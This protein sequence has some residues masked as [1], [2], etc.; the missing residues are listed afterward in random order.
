MLVVLSQTKCKGKL[1]GYVYHWL[2]ALAVAAVTCADSN[3]HRNG[4][5]IT[6]VALQY[7]RTRRGLEPKW[8]LLC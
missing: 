8:L 2:A 3:M 4:R 5:N 1:V 7:A 6:I